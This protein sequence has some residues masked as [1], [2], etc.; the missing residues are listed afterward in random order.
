[1]IY[2]DNAATTKVSDEVRAAMMPFLEEAYGNP[3]S[4]HQAG[5]K[6]RQAVDRARRHIASWLGCDAHDLV[7]TSGGTEANATALTG[8]YLARREAKRHIITSAVEHHAVLHTLEFLESVGAEVTVL[9]V[10]GDGCVRVEDVLAA[11]REDTGVV[12][13]MAVNN[14]IGTIQPIDQVVQAVKSVDPSI[15]VHSDMV[16]ALPFIAHPLK[17]LPVDMATF[18]AHKIHGPKGMGLLYLR[19]DVPWR[20]MLYGGQ[21]EGRRRGGTEN[22]A[23]I[24]GFGTA[25]DLLSSDFERRVAHIGS[26][27]SAFF[28]VLQRHCNAVLL[29]PAD[30]APTILS[31]AFPGV[32][33]D[34]L[35]MRLDLAGVAASAGSA[36]TAGSLEPSHVIAA[37]GRTEYLKEA[38]RFSFSD[39]LSM[40]QVLEAAEIVCTTV[41]T[42]TDS[43]RFS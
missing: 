28:D 3:S 8:A 24:V 32:R 29:S 27:R 20:P 15:V 2:L 43:A 35:L 16:Q 17:R 21:Q 11:L 12:S 42:I 22:V 5:R 36:C 25:V 9:P 38:V 6:A 40:D 31:L 18:S 14:E 13:I 33:N 30:G 10:D 19:K 39:D 34:T 1:M 23:G 41:K 4:I 7:F 37:T 26:L